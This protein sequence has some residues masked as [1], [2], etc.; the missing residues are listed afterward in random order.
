MAHKIDPLTAGFSLGW[1]GYAGAQRGPR[2]GC[3]AGRVHQVLLPHCSWRTVHQYR[4]HI[5]PE[6]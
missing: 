2:G 4:R 1:T 5:R 3:L 6:R